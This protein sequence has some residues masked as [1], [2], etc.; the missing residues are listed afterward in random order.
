VPVPKYVR[1]PRA[2]YA[3]TKVPHNASAKLEGQMPFTPIDLVMKRVEKFG[4]SDSALFT[5]LLYAG[6]IIVKITTAAL[7][8]ST[9]DDREGHRYRLL[10]ALVRA[11]G[12]GEWASKLEDALTGSAS[13]HLAAALADDRRAAARLSIASI[14]KPH[15]AS[16]S[17]PAKQM[18]RGQ[19][20]RKFTVAGV[21]LFAHRVSS[22]QDMIFEGAD[23]RALLA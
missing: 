2:T 22:R 10:H 21:R 13:Q 1:L 6:E 20:H 18:V 4:E 16:R 11:D 8:A 14:R 3:T 12:I 7:V 15:G 19:Q 17:S 23:V 5:E 9:E